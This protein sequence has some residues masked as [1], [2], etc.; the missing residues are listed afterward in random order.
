MS[1]IKSYSVGNGDMF[2]I[3]HNS[4]SFTIIDCCLSEDNKAGILKDI[5]NAQ[6][7][8]GIT[9]FISTHPDED[10]ILGLKYLD[11]KLRLANFYCI[12][13]KITKEDESEDFEHYCGLRDSDKAFFIRRGATRKWMNKEDEMRGSAGIQVLW[14]IV[15][16][17]DYKEAL[18]TAEAGES[19]NNVSAVL[20][21]RTGDI[22]LMWMGD[23]ETDFMEKIADE[24][25]W[26]KVEILFAAHHGRKSGRVP[27]SILDQLRPKII[28][29][30]EAPS[31]HL[32][33]YGGYE[34][35]T[36]NSTGDIIFE[37][38]GSKVHIFTSEDTYE[39]SHLDD[40]KVTGEGAYI[41]TL[42]V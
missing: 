20:T 16:N 22:S 36:Q 17:S 26:P 21:Y 35:L 2:Y 9:R 19:P 10:H 37:C 12:K 6:S 30:G 28:V 8:K 29:I 11:D 23:L 40:E 39:V 25:D 38:D 3:N 42:N 32:N 4:D 14:P 24:V 1:T 13:N 5:R 33:Y 31:R 15:D 41:G 18:A 27:H 34:T 7:G